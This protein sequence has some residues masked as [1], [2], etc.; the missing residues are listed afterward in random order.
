MHIISN[1]RLAPIILVLVT[2]NVA[3]ILLFS[4]SGLVSYVFTLFAFSLIN[5][6]CE[7]NARVNN[8]L[9]FHFFV[10]L[11]LI[12]MFF[13]YIQLPEY[14]G[15]SGP[16]SVGTDDVNYYA[17]VTDDHLT[18]NVERWDIAYENTYSKLIKF[19]YPF[20]FV[21]PV[22]A[23]IINILG[24]VFIPYLTN[25][26]SYNF[27]KDNRIAS[28]SERLCL[29][30]PFI[31][32]IGLIIMR[33][34]VCTSLV[35]LA[36]YCILLRRYIAFLFVLLLLGYIKLG[37]II[38][39]IVAI[40]IY[41]IKDQLSNGE[42]FIST[43]IMARR[44]LKMAIYALFLLIAIAFYV[45][46]NL[47]QITQGRLEA[48][49]FFRTTFIEYLNSANDGS[50]LV[51]IY[52][53]PI[54]VRIPVLIVTFVII[55][56]LTFNFYIDNFFSFRI[57]LQNVLAPLLWCYL[58]FYL[59]RFLYSYRVL[60][61]KGRTLF[62]IIIMIS[63]SLGMISLQSRHKVVLVPFM[64]MAVAYS[65]CYLKGRSQILSRI[66]IALFVLFQFVMGF[67]R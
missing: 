53:L 39:L 1:K 29:T 47:E 50:F 13:N 40:I 56:P 9:Y 17:G 34:V 62:W 14:M 25:R 63:L 41:Y 32:S 3:F 23:I 61:C 15:L 31:L 5:H 64:Y 45:I 54:I 38:F 30:C 11:A 8:H 22:D 6:F 59:F 55:P 35:L 42:T 46:P 66:S 37:Y 33:D 65:M 52:D 44:W 60:G 21:H 18:Y 7:K 26:L 24:V 36:F 49:S 58:F 16:S 12:Y 28:I 48:G 10:F 2:I 4:I 43:R 20:G 19:I 27:F 57:F 67:L 51:K